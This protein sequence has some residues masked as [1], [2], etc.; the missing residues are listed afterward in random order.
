MP[1]G[2]AVAWPVSP[3]LAGHRVGHL[4]PTCSQAQ[5][6][7]I[8][9]KTIAPCDT[10][11]NRRSRSWRRQ[12]GRAARGQLIRGGQ[13]DAPGYQSTPRQPLARAPRGRLPSPR[14][15]NAALRHRV[16]S[17]RLGTRRAR[18]QG[19]PG[20]APH[21]SADWSRGSAPLSGSPLNRR[22]SAY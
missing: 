16:S 20:Q 12:A 2:G 22:S 19:Y 17:D 5:L 9:P 21:L 7:E 14:A 13:Y 4:V 8:A 11:W 10:C 3:V 15:R 6:C 1:A 18:R